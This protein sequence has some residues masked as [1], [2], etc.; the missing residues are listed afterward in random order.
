MDNE[1]LDGGLGSEDGCGRRGLAWP[2]GVCSP[3]GRR[4][5]RVVG[6]LSGPWGCSSSV[7]RRRRLGMVIVAAEVSGWSFGGLLAVG[8]GLI[9]C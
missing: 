9:E 2:A 7:T 8:E 1:G 6:W 5:R 4:F 3:E